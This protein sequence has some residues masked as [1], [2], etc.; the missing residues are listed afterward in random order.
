MDINMKLN[1]FDLNDKSWILLYN[2]GDCLFN[3]TTYLLKYS[4]NSKEICKNH[5]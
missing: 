5:M 1:E 4:M 2:V 3:V